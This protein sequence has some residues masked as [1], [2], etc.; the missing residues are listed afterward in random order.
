[1]WNKVLLHEWTAMDEVASISP[2]TN[3]LVGFYIESSFAYQKNDIVR[4]VYVYLS[5]NAMALDGGG[6]VD[7][8][9][10][11][12]IAYD[13]LSDN[14]FNLS[15]YMFI[16]NIYYSYSYNNVYYDYAK[17]FFGSSTNDYITY[18]QT[19]PANIKLYYGGQ[20]SGTP[21][22]SNISVKLYGL[23]EK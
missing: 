17:I 1:M 16:D 6:Q 9:T 14:T 3:K 11:A 15:K 19:K 23:Y 20:Y 2:V 5:Q 18:L 13:L 12:I 21:T 8:H 4:N 10:I 7:D 22:F